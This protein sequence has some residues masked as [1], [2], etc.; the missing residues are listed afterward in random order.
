[1]FVSDGMTGVVNTSTRPCAF[2]P[3]AVVRRLEEAATR[4]L[5]FTM[6]VT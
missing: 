4:E 2:L 3:P 5:G 1:M 6:G